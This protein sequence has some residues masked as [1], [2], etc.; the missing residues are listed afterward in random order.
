MVLFYVVLYFTWMILYATYP[1]AAFLLSFFIQHCFWEFS[2]LVH[3]GVVHFI[4]VL[5]S[6]PFCEWATVDFSIP[7]L[8][9]THSGCFHS[10]SIMSSSSLSIT[11]YVFLHACLSGSINCIPSSGLARSRSARL[12]FHSIKVWCERAESFFYKSVL[13]KVQF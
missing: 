5:C 13:N 11:A 1:F 4:E 9:R 2:M 6:A 7:L 8:V 3:A 10:F 12:P